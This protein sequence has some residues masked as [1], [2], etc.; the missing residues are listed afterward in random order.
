MAGRK[1]E[2][3]KIEPSTLYAGI[4]WWKQNH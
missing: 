2:G 4:G 3:Y 1:K